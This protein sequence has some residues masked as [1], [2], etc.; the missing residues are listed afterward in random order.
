MSTVGIEYLGDRVLLL[1]FGESIDI[2]LNA[3][4]HACAQLIRAARLPGLRDLVPA[5]ASLAVHYDPGAWQAGDVGQ[6]PGLRLAALLS[7]LVDDADFSEAAAAS[8]CVEVP[9]CYARDFALDLGEIVRHT[10]LPRAEVVAR[11]TGGDY[12]VAML[13]F[14]PGFPY[15][16]GLDP[17]LHTPRRANPRTQ[18]PAG[19]VAIGGAQ[20]GIYPHALPGGWQILGRTPLRLFDPARTPSALLGAAQRVRFRAIDADEFSALSAPP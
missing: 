15:L 20:T 14:A 12:R 1:R 8:G 19:S 7:A 17:A 9:V 18:V 4:V 2:A 6:A 13:G 5:Y 10:G 3:R 11:H 16:L